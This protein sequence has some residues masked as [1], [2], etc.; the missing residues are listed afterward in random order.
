MTLWRCPTL[1]SSASARALTRCPT[2]VRCPNGGDE[3][4][5]ALL[6]ERCGRTT[7]ALQQ[8]NTE[9]TPAFEIFYIR[10]LLFPWAQRLGHHVVLALLVL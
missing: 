7:E 8:G 1:C 5:A 9:L 4:G 3:N 10:A 2:W 6:V